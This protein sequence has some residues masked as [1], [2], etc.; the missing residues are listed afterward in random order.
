[1]AKK[2]KNK[3]GN[4]NNNNNIDLSSTTS[5]ELPESEEGPPSPPS[6][7]PPAETQGAVEAPA[8]DTAS[9]A[10][11]ESDLELQLAAARAEIE[12][13]KE[14]LQAKDEELISLRQASARAPV[15]KVDGSKAED[16]QKMQEKLAQLKK[17]Q[18][19]ADINREAAW[20]QLKSVV[21]EI[22]KLAQP[23]QFT[24]VAS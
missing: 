12:A 15:T 22:S 16:M 18:T 23:E 5:R 13:L 6:L 10:T 9:V 2:N 4:N 11:S 21:Q 20:R 17:E 19:E 8:I 24:K 1:M 14:Q 3:N 7:P